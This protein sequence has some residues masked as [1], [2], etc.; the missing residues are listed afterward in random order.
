MFRSIHRAGAAALGAA[1]AL[2]IPLAGCGTSGSAGADPGSSAPPASAAADVKGAC[3][4]LIR[5]DA[6]PQPGEGPGAPASAAEIKKFGQS[7]LAPLKD[8]LESRNDALA[9]S[10]KVLEPVAVAAAE[11]GTPIPD[12]DSV[13]AAVTEYHR[14]AHQNCGYQNV[15]LMAVDYAFDRMPATLKA[16]PVSLSLMNHS[17]KGEF[18]VA[19]ILRPN[20]PDLTTVEQLLAIPLR[21]LAGRTDV[22]GTAAAAPGMTGG[23]L[24]DLKP[25]RYFVV[26]PV[27]VGGDENSDDIHMLHGMASVIEVA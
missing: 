24:L 13:N 14:W 9:A 21:E 23:V 15:D 27:P 1:V 11:N 18:H 26:C 19:L 10:L 12:D 22:L 6:V 7:V 25:G 8:A 17:D 2:S 4:S 5:I 20:D 16:G 3:A